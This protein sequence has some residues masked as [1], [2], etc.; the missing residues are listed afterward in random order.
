MCKED[1]A[2]DNFQCLIYPKTKPTKLN[3]T[4]GFGIYYNILTI[5]N[6]EIDWLLVIELFQLICKSENLNF[7]FSL[8]EMHWSSCEFLTPNEIYFL[9]YKSSL[10]NTK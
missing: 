7:Y 8:I 1:L 4:Y 5:R 10:T 3:V 2:L 9:S 6:G